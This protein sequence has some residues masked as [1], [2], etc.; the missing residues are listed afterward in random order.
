MHWSVGAVL[1]PKILKYV[2][3]G[4]NGLFHFLLDISEK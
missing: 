2:D 1:R 3:F 4:S